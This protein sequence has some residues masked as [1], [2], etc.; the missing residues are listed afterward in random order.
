MPPE[1]LTKLQ[2]LYQDRL[3]IGSGICEQHG[4][5][6][7]YH[8]SYP[9]E[10]VIY[11]ESTAEISQIL[12]L[13]HEYQT[14][15]IAFG[16]GT[17]LEGQV[18]ALK[19]GVC[20]DLSQMKKVVEFNP[21]D[22]DIKVEAGLT[23]RELNQYLNGSGL[24]FPVDPGADATL[25]GMCATR[26]SG[27]NAVRYGTMRENV[28]GLT[29]IM[30][31]GRIIQTGGRA[32]K[33]AAGYDLTR[34]F[35]G[36]EGTLGIIS[37]IRLRLHPLP[38]EV[39]AAVCSFPSVKAAANAV[40]EI[41]Q[42]AI[43]VARIEFLDGLCMKAVN[44][45]SKLDYPEIPTL[46]LEFH[47]QKASVA[48]Q[49]RLSGEILQNHDGGEFNWAIKPEE[50]SRLW[51]ARH[52][53]YPSLKAMNPGLSA[54]T[55]DVCVPISRLA[56][57]IEES[58]AQ[59]QKSFIPSMIV[60]HVGDGNFHQIYFFDRT[61][62]H[63]QKEAQRLSDAQV[64]LALQLGGTCSGEHGIGMG[65]VK[66]LKAEHGEGVEIMRLIKQALDPLDLLNPGK[67]L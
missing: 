62:P 31:D 33:S 2:A 51:R 45:Y 35:I 23:H 34:L 40:I 54:L 20:I 39:A 21:E 10:A 55:S 29:V 9:P 28:L 47:G 17:S 3:T 64:E 56:Q 15:V 46:F 63:E 66:Y 12:K 42:N 27:T 25:G 32:R 58:H 59:A 30:A 37:E 67:M 44:Q 61:K 6:E 4:K 60:G 22:F 49:A 1:L 38:E 24:F 16:V 13:C 53:A 26:A 18:A 5:G 14:K 36:S 41:L 43:P 50:R 57:C 65:K 8:P 11:P 19:G 7:S 52:D 48:E